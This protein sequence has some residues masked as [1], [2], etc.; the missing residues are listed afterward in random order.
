MK[1]GNSMI[2]F[3]T[4]ADSAYGE[5]QDGGLPERRLLLAMLERSI[6]D[7]VGNDPRE[8]ESAAEWLFADS[9]KELDEGGEPFSFAWVCEG[10]DLDPSRVSAFVRSLPKRGSRRVAPWYFMDRAQVQAAT[11]ELVRACGG[12]R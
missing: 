5:A 12:I 11:T 2:T 7:F 3:S 4:D 10:L 1:T 9:G 8:V 6:L